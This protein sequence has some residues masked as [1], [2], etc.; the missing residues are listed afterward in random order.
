MGILSRI[1]ALSGLCALLAGCSARTDGPAIQ[2][3]ILER[4]V[5]IPDGRARVFF[6]HGERVTGVNEFEPH[7][8]LEI[9]RVH[10]GPRRVSA[11]RYLVSRVQPVSTEIVMAAPLRQV[12]GV[13]FGV[14]IHI[15]IGSFGIGRDDSPPDIFEGY[16]F[17]VVDRSDVGLMRLTCLG[18]RAEPA[19]VA[20][21]TRAEIRRAL[22]N[23]MRLE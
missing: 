20:P 4:P 23:W 1:L 12:A 13:D 17:W 8:G 22:G 3:L 5:D 10:G 6:Q 7:C 21:P 14:G 11:G 18:A 2:A 16:H 9:R 19:D 15:G